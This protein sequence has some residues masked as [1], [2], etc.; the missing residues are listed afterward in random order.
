MVGEQFV[1]VVQKG[2]PFGLNHAHGFVSVCPCSGALVVNGECDC[3]CFDCLGAD[4]WEGPLSDKVCS[5]RNAGD[6][7]CYIGAHGK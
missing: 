2:K 3:V 4:A 1:V 6:A 7:N 5:G